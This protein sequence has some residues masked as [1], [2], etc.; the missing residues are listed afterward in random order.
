MSFFFQPRITYILRELEGNQWRSK[1]P[2]HPESERILAALS[3]NFSLPTT[4]GG[5]KSEVKEGE[6]VGGDATVKHRTEA[7]G[8]VED[9]ERSG[10][11]RSGDMGDGVQQAEKEDSERVKE[12]GMEGEQLFSIPVVTSTATTPG[13]YSTKVRKPVTTH[14]CLHIHV[15][16]YV[17]AH[18]K[19][20]CNLPHNTH[21]SSF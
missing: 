3:S 4:G 10:E 19:H 15:R 9:G 21:I 13:H 8:K 7:D 16:C 20:T 14:T 17:Q 11:E 18:V 12:E 2:P 1:L 6:S 5:G